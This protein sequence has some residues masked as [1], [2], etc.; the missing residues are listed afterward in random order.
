[1]DVQSVDRKVGPL[2]LTHIK[3]PRFKSPIHNHDSSLS[4][5]NNTNSV[6][7][8]IRLPFII[9]FAKTTDPLC[10]YLS[11]VPRPATH[12]NKTNLPHQSRQHWPRNLDSS[13][14]G[15]RRHSRL[16]SR[17]QTSSRALV[18]LAPL[19]LPGQPSIRQFPGSKAKPRATKQQQDAGR[20]SGFESA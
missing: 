10:K 11:Y 5:D 9:P 2:Q 14:N 4:S 1:M 15:H 17:H 3:Y 7:S 19:F 8:V 13:R 6:H 18:S 20:G 16:P 12:Q